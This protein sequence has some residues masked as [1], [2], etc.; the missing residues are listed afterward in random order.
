MEVE[1]IPYITSAINVQR[2][3]LANVALE[4]ATLSVLFIYLFNFIFFYF[5]TEPGSL[6]HIRCSLDSLLVNAR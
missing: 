5:E 4:S 3:F 2:G 6:Y 1:F